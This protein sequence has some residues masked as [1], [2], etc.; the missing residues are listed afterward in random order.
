MS[1]NVKADEALDPGGKISA[2]IASY[3]AA[4]FHIFN[5]PAGKMAEMLSAAQTVLRGVKLADLSPGSWALT[6]AAQVGV[7]VGYGS[8]DPAEKDARRRDEAEKQAAGTGVVLDAYGH[9]NGHVPLA[10]AMQRG[11]DTG[12]RANYQEISY[13]TSQSIQSITPSGYA[14]TPFAEAGVN[15]GT[16]N[17][18]RHYDRNFTGQNILNAAQDVKKL[19]L[20]TNNKRAMRAQTTIDHYDNNKEATNK[21]IRDY[22]HR[23]RGDEELNGWIRALTHATGKEREA[24]LAKI[25]AR[26]AEHRGTSGVDARV[27]DPKNHP[28]AKHA[29]PVQVDEVDKKQEL[30]LNRDQQRHPTNHPTDP[31]QGQRRSEIQ[32]R[33]LDRKIDAARDGEQA[34]VEAGE[35]GIDSRR[36]ARADAM[37]ALR[38]SHAEK[39]GTTDPPVKDAS[40]SPAKGETKPER[41]AKSSNPEAGGAKSDPPKKTVAAKPDAGPKP[42]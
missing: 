20:D 38:K 14:R 17:Y 25:K 36:A 37:A 19:G 5:I 29:I 35:A 28:K 16:F 22:A 26:R 23:T 12:S 13:T 39:T 6:Q 2:A 33:E 21:A 34:R 1:L 9:R 7:A 24:L 30:D 3:A 40:K 32:G 4:N 27:A 42:T 11:G 41:E 18:L 8:Q 31:A 15:Y 10:L